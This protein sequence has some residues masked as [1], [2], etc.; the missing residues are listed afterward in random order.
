[1]EAVVI[2]VLC[3]LWIGS[4]LLVRYGAYRRGYWEGRVDGMRQVMR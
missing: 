4:L 2:G 1:M 3:I